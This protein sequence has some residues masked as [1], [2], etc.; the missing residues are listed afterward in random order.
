MII[1]ITGG[2]G[3]IGKRLLDNLL[4]TNFE[5]R[6]L[7][8][9]PFINKNRIKFFLGDLTSPKDDLSEFLDGVDVLYHCA[10]EINNENL[11]HELHVNGTK[12]LISYAKGNIGLWVQLSS[13][14]AYGNHRVGIV[15]EKS[16]ENPSGMYE[17][18]KTI[19]DNLVIKS[20]IPFA[21]V[22]RVLAV[23]RVVVSLPF[24]L[25]KILSF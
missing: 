20:G 3:Y 14:G 16:K 12:R 21:I 11:M 25:S 5:I 15:S 1:A 19:S 2:S 23:P 7:S 4:N 8:R 13:V 18:T 6:L 10:G 17:E 24:C 9:K 22:R